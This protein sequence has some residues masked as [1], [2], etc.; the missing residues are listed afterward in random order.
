[1][2]A[3]ATVLLLLCSNIFMT[4]AWYGHLKRPAW[5][6]LLAILISWMIALPEYMLQ[7]PANR[8]G[9]VSMGGPFTASQLKVIQE[10][11]TLTVFIGFAIIVLRER[12]RLNEYIAFG[13]ILLAVVVAMLGR[14]EPNLAPATAA[15]HAPSGAAAPAPPPPT[16][17]EERGAETVTDASGPADPHRPSPATVAPAGERN[18]ESNESQN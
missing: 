5:P 10:A 11:V 17:I 16:T 4:W 9:H 15:E 7:V 1:M 18:P 12:P 14:R 13:L 3:A 8:L 2:R 6:L